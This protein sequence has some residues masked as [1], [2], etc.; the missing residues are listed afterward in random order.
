MRYFNLG[1]LGSIL[2]L[3]GTVAALGANTSQTEAVRAHMECVVKNVAQL[4]DGKMA[5]E[6]LAGMIV[7]L[8]HA[9]H[10]AA[11]KATNG[12]VDAQQLELDHTI[13]AVLLARSLHVTH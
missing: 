1:I 10:A 2:I 5:P 4:D 8:C 7:P 13:A 3:S 6:V 9:A 11:M 12:S